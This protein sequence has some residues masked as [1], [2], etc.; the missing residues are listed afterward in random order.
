[1]MIFIKRITNKFVRNLCYSCR[2][3]RREYQAIVKDDP[4]FVNDSWIYTIKEL[5]FLKKKFN[6][7]VSTKTFNKNE[8]II[9]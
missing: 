6:I 5:G 2:I 9:M 7:T 1:M 4:R 8:I 3:N